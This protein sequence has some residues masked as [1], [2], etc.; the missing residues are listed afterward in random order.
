MDRN[1]QWSGQ[2]VAPGEVIRDLK[3]RNF[4]S[5]SPVDTQGV[6]ENKSCFLFDLWFRGSLEFSKEGYERYRNL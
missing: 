1:P 6:L 2:R 3:W 4:V 5:Q